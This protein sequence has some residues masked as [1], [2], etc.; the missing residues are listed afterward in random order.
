MHLLGYVIMYIV[1]QLL[2]LIISDIYNAW[3]SKHERQA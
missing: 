2:G 3:K 1:G